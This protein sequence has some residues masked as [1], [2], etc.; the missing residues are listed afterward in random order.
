MAEPDWTRIQ[1]LFHQACELDEPERSAFLDEAC[2]DREDERRL[3]EKM[4]ESDAEPPDLLRAEPGQLAT[5][6]IDR[7]DDLPERIGPYAVER[8]IGR[9]GM[10][11][12]VLA[13][14]PDLPRKVALKLVRDRWVG[15]EAARRFKREESVLARLQ[16]PHIARLLDAGTT[17]DGT[18]YLTMDYVDGKPVTEYCD[19]FELSID[20]KLALMIDVCEAVRYAHQNLVVHRDLKP[21]NILVDEAG[22]IKLLDFGIAKLLEDENE[23]PDTLTSNRLMTPLYASPEQL[24]GQPVTT[25]TDVYSLGVVMCELLTGRRPYDLEGRSAT[26][27]LRVLTEEAPK[28]PSTMAG[29]ESE[30]R[31][32]KGDLDNILLKALQRDPAAR[33]ASMEA[34]LADIQRHLKGFP[35]DAR[36]ATVPY[37]LRK[38]LS[39]HKVGAGIAIGIAILMAAFGTTIVIQRSETTRERDRAERQ[40]ARAERTAD[41]LMG[42]FRGQRSGTGSWRHGQRPAASR[43]RHRAG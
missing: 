24:A 34:M 21:S 10:G 23:D 31:R 36:E 22:R 5:L 7:T 38:F 26:E 9:G 29:S 35:V 1:D 30:R 20:Q 42:L 2:G 3:V 19:E 41:F 15:S 40:T 14:R 32:L 39:R 6:L 11:I 18:P 13:E 17:D 43:T 33:Y 16:H 12:V 28:R 4:L 27:A 25:A 8:L 37:R